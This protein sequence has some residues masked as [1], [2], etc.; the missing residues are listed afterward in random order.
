MVQFIDGSLIAQM[1]SPDMRLPISYALFFPDRTDCGVPHFDPIKFGQPLTFE[2]PDTTRFPCL[3]LARRAMSQG[4]TMPA[5][6]NGAN[7][8]LVQLFLNTKIGFN[9]IPS[10]LEAVMDQHNPVPAE[11]LAVIETA[12]SWARGFA[13]QLADTT[14]AKA[15]F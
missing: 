3:E 1:G 9:S 6:L 7:E 14:Q 11:T 5:V 15:S 2:K 12:D 13:Q 4:G 10:L 8:H